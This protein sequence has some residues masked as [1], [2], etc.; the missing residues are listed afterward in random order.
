MLV[1]VTLRELIFRFEGSRSSLRRRKIADDPSELRCREVSIERQP[2][3]RQR[4]SFGAALFH[5]AFYVAVSLALG[6]AA[7]VP[8]PWTLLK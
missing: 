1:Q 2:C 7:G 4:Q 6:F 5:Y 3:A 8:M